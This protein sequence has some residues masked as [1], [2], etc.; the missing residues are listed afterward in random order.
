M[1]ASEAVTALARQLA[2]Q[3]QLVERPGPLWTLR[4]ETASLNQ[5]GA[6]ERLRAALQAEGL[7]EQLQVE[8]GAVTDSPARRNAVAAHARQ[9]IA[10]QIVRGDPM[11]QTLVREHGAK[12]VPG[13][14]RPISIAADRLP[15]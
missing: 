11:V 2:L 9:R 1:I 5:N 6:R 12:I 4:V 13:S 14:I 15:D 3:A 8:Q 7:A 10:E